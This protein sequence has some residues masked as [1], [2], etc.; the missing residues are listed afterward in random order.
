MA[1]STSMSRLA[2]LL[3]RRDLV[4]AILLVLVIFMMILPLPTALVDTLI[5]I[6]MGLSIVMLMV[7]VYLRTPVHFTTLPSVLLIATL[8]RLSLSITTTR[9]ILVQADAGQIVETFGSLVIAGDLIVG[10]VV[11]LIITIVQFV[12]ITKGSER[13]AEVGA[14]F[15]LDGMPGKQISIDSD[16]RAGSIDLV[17]A[18]R[19]RTYLEKESQLYGAMDGAMKFVKGDA[20]A[21]LIIIAVNLLGGIGIGAFSRGMELRDAVQVYSLLTIGDGLVAQIPALFL[22]I[23]AGMIVTR[24]ADE[25][26]KDLGTDISQQLLQDRRALQVGAVVLAGFALVP[27]FPTVIFLVLA[28]LAGL[29]GFGV[30]GRFINRGEPEGGEKEV[31]WSDGVEELPAA[32]LNSTT[33]VLI[34]LDASLAD[35]IRPAEIN[36][37]LRALRERYAQEMGVPFPRFSIRFSDA[38]NDGAIHIDVNDVP[39]SLPFARLRSSHLLVHATA[40]QLQE[41][42]L[43]YDTES[44][45]FAWVANAQQAA[46]NTHALTAMDAPAQLLYLFEKVLLQHAAQ[47]VGIQETKAILDQAAQTHADLVSETQQVINLLR[48]N[49]VLKRLLAEQVPIR[50]VRLI[51]EALCEWGQKEKDPAALAEYARLALRRQICH[52]LSLGSGKLSVLMLD[53]K[54]EDT[55]R[56]NV[57]QTSSGVFLALDSQ[58]RKSLLESLRQQLAALP[59]QPTPYVVLTTADLRPHLYRMFFEDGLVITVLA[60]T[61]LPPEVNV[62][63]MGH[64]QAG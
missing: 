35:V 14:R 44:E 38:V 26:S 11:F 56:N 1:T 4:L 39:A 3:A 31:F 57:R 23:A 6:N 58:Y 46:L 18:K 62:I 64:I 51:L 25:E 54:V 42:K 55:A 63:T 43:P 21:G 59:V 33:P 15:T 5:A 45:Q 28:A 61:E 50:H 24:V 36:Q 20:I 37:H 41:H 7:A 8:F 9:L 40:Q 12:V 13:V 29:Y 47:F 32:L 34:R 16:L 48:I 17:E 30:I 53:S 19:R 22:S 27:G 49:D 52:R 60:R 2:A 10:L